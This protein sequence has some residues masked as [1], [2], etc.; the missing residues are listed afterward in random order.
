MATWTGYSPT[1]GVNGANVASVNGVQVDGK[2]PIE[3]RAGLLM[4]LEGFRANKALLADLIGAATGDTVTANWYRVKGVQALNDRTALG[5]AVQIETTFA[6]GT[7]TAGRA[8]TAADVTALK[9]IV[10]MKS[11]LDS[12]SYPVDLSGNGGG[13]QLTKGRTV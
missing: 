9:A 1:M 13:G 12:G 8:T 5:G 11:A 3:K 2:S 7:T 6:L 10:N 4:Q